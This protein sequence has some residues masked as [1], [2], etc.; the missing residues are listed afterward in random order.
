MAP[1]PPAPPVPLYPSA[2][3]VVPTKNG[4]LN[5]AVNAAVN[6]LVAA[7]PGKPAAKFSLSLIDM[8]NNGY[9]V[10]ND[11]QE[12]YA[13]SAVKIAA[14]YGAYALFGM[15]QR[16]NTLRSP[17]TPKALFDGLRR[18]MNGAIERSSSL[19]MGGVTG[20]YRV[21]NYEQVFETSTVGAKLMLRFHRNYAAAMDDMIVLS[22]NERTAD[23]VHG[24][25]YGYLNGALEKGGFFKSAGKKG[26]W[27]A[28]DY[29]GAWPYVR[30]PS[31][32]DIDTAQGA[33]SL[34][35]AHLMAVMI[36]DDI[37]GHG[38]H[39]EMTRRLK[40]AAFASWFMAKEVSNRLLDTQV[41]HAK[42]GVGPMK[43][44]TGG[45]DVYSEATVLRGI[46]GSGRTYVTAF[47]NVDYRPYAIDHVLDV[48]KDAI[49]RYER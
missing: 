46:E 35:L 15:V 39:I 33:T 37:L 17:D 23:C 12:H 20:K 49:K 22:K 2:P 4:K 34:S 27:L 41:L 6:D 19:I 43:K 7:M 38:S 26:V 36:W 13:A 14:M 48:I 25:G 9:G 3:T 5:D 8:S 44:T 42:I 29:T 47:T 24:V 21:P 32:N 31:D 1:P 18:D 16:Y 10:F 28:G 11:D 40:R 30:I 45:H